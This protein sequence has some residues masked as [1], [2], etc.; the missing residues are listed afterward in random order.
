MRGASAAVWRSEVQGGMLCDAAQAHPVVYDKVGLELLKKT[1][2]V[3]SLFP[4]DAT[5]RIPP[6]RWAGREHTGCLQAS[7]GTEPLGGCLRCDLLCLDTALCVLRLFLVLQKV[8]ICF[9][10]QGVTH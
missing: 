10:A 5:A 9:P 1:L 8:P 7:R 2:W 4:H 6:R 3:Y